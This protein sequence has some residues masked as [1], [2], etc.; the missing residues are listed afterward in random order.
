MARIRTGQRQPHPGP[1]GQGRHSH[2]TGW[3]DNSQFADSGNNMRTHRHTLSLNESNHDE[4]SQ[5]GHGYSDGGQDIE[6]DYS[7]GGEEHSHFH[8]YNPGF[9]PDQAW[10]TGGH[11][12]NNPHTPEDAMDFMDHH[13]GGRHMH[14]M[15]P[16]GSAGGEWLHHLGF[17]FSEDS[18]GLHQHPHGGGE[19]RGGGHNGRQLQRFGHQKSNAPRIRG[20]VSTSPVKGGYR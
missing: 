14:M 3:H 4:Y 15:L 12:P 5:H 20:G 8:N 19:V 1:H 11:D 17:D 6:W 9:Q 13:A 7:S 2:K 16:Y 18:R 10:Y